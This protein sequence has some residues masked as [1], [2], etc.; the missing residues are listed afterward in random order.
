MNYRTIGLIARYEVKATSREWSFKIIT[1]LSVL[2]VIFL[3]VVTQ[4]NL[5]EPEW[6]AISLSSAI[7]FSNAYLVNFFQIIIAIFFAGNFLQENKYFDS[8]SSLS[9]RPFSNIELLFGKTLGFLIVIFCLDLLLG[10]IALLIHLFMSESPFGFYPYLFYFFTLTCPTL[11]FITG[12][13]ICVKGITRNFAL[14][15]VLL[16]TFLYFGLFPGRELFYGVFDPLALSLPNSFSEVTG[17]FGLNSY[18][19]QRFAFLMWGCGLITL[20]ITFVYRLSNSSKTNFASGRVGIL[21]LVI[22]GVASGFYISKEF[23][24]VNEREVARKTF[25]KYQHVPKV[26]VLEHDIKF[27]QEGYTYLASSRLS[28]FN[29]NDQKIDSVVLYLNTGLNVSK[30]TSGNEVLPYHRDQQVLV[31]IL[32]M[33][34]GE[35]REVEM[36]YRGTISPAVCYAEV[37]DI[38]SLATAA[39]RYYMYNMGR[40]Y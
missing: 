40:D 26:N 29:P 31:L 6:I 23:R 4:S 36:D 9:V 21:F 5:K 20:G 18:L 1:L 22:G 25:V 16:L 11:V 3:H 12:L 28:L 14:S 34:P 13:A 2:I 33:L 30:L 15:F 7:P 19:L 27:E 37:V 35:T 39:R 8:S 10:V 32:P 38:D 17:F 24:Q